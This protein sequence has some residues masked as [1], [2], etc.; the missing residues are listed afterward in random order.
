MEERWRWRPGGGTYF[1]D[2]SCLL[3]GPRGECLE[4]V[5]YR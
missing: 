1:L 5:D 4:A 3:Y 2:A